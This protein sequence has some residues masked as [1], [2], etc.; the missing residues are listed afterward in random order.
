MQLKPGRYRHYKGKDYRVIGIARH[1]E[2]E[3]PLVVYRTLYGEFDLWV[4]PLEMFTEMVVVEGKTYP[5]FTFIS[6]DV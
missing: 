5:R 4:R 6:E 1:S 2:T 3:E